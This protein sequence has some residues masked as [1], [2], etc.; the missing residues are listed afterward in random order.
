MIRLRLDDQ[1]EMRQLQAEYLIRLVKCKAVSFG[2]TQIAD[3]IKQQFTFVGDPGIECD[4]D[5]VRE[6]M[7]IIRKNDPGLYKFLFPKDQLNVANLVWVLIGIPPD[8]PNTLSIR[9]NFEKIILQIEHHRD[10]KEVEGEQ[11]K[12]IEKIFCFQKL[13]K[14]LPSDNACG[15][16]DTAYWLQKRL[17]IHICPYC[18]ANYTRISVDGRFRADLEHFF[19]QSL[20]PYL[21]VSLFNLFP[22]CQ[23]CN[24][25][26]SNR[27]NRIKTS[28]GEKVVGQG[29]EIIFPYDESFDDGHERT[30][31]RIIIDEGASAM[32][33][34]YGNSDRFSIVLV[35]TNGIDSIALSG[36]AAKKTINQMWNIRT[37]ANKNREYWNRVSNSIII[38]KLQELYDIHKPEVQKLLKNHYIYNRAGIIDRLKLFPQTGSRRTATLTQE[39]TATMIKDLLFFTDTSISCWG[40]APLNKLKADILDQIESLEHDLNRGTEEKHGNKQKSEG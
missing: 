27:S 10:G 23:T 24:K 34:F 11:R 5:D 1:K 25:L 39:S 22:A 8:G 7:D 29:K 40:N 19:P 20:Y 12:A 13:R 6:A 28:Q 9:E 37:T 30:A 4:D 2:G 14:N 18:N 35:P 3:Y 21:S 26:K 31:F 15:G 36:V 16:L 33:V 17:N 32:D 38:F